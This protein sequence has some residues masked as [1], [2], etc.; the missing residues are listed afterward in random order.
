MNGSGKSEQ[1]LGRAFALAV[2]LPVLLA[3]CAMDP[4]P[5]V[6]DPPP[7][8]SAATSS[9]A[10]TVVVHSGDTLS[11]IA[12]SR[13]VR[14]AEI[15]RLNGLRDRDMIYAGQVLRIPE[16]NVRRTAVRAA[17]VYRPSP[18]PAYGSYTPVSYAPV[19]YSP[20]EARAAPD[21]RSALLERAQ[22]VIDRFSGGSASPQTAPTTP[23]ATLD[24]LDSA[25]FVWPV[26]GRII[27]PFGP[28]PS[29]ERNDGIN[30]ATAMRTPI[31]AA[32]AGTV[33]YAGNELKGYG[34][35][36]LIRHDDGYV[37]A[38][39]HADSLVVT[40]GDRV[41]RGQV[42]GYSGE[43]GD[44]SEP[45][46]HFEIRHGVTPIDPKPLLMARAS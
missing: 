10:G 33:T 24:D 38:Y 6:G 41:A 4:E 20:V 8:R 28:A 7:A 21:T 14:V 17:S 31:H 1:G 9:Y 16:R 27:M 40:R 32:A 45:Q 39:A 36:V 26:M 22:D 23:Q 3:G 13:G 15:V 11:G 37:T 5:P 42:I 19:S 12:L 2:I 29:G 30:I 44:V 46:L 34:N 18:R 35:L 25:R 43:S